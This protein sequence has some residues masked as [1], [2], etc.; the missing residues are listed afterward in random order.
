MRITRRAFNTMTA[1][2]AA[3]LAFASRASA[4]SVASIMPAG[5]ID[6]HNHVMGPQS[7]YPYSANRPYTPPEANVDDLKRLRTQI[8]VARNVI[9]TPT[10][11]G[12]DNRSTVDAVTEL[13]ATARGVVLLPPDVSESELNRLE[14]AG[15]RGARLNTQNPALKE[16][17]TTWAPKFKAIN[18]HVQIVGQLP[19]IVSLGPQIATLGHP[20]VI[21]NF[22]GARGEDGVQ[23]K[24]FQAFLELVR[25][26]NVYVKLS[27]P[28]DRTR[29]PGYANMTPFARALI[30]ARADRML[31]GTNWPHPLPQQGVP[32][33]QI[34]PYQNVDNVML[35]TRLAEWCP[36]TATRKMILVD[37][38]ERLYRFP[39][40]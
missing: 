36:D 19:I 34:S 25:T 39:R 11:Y 7:K 9:V 30:A 12:F 4:A 32:I 22:G 31:W 26:R 18:W 35:V 16:T 29:E 24:D 33:T 13:G 14:T 37:T 2:A 21:D 10:P 23:N 17:L 6:T 28:Y 38:P 40:A 8:G 3:S 15:I 1:G 20:V 5:A 27:A